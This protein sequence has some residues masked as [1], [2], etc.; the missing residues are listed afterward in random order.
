MVLSCVVMWCVQL[1]NP[2]YQRIRKAKGAEKFMLS[3]GYEISTQT[4]E[5][6]APAAA[7]LAADAAAAQRHAQRTLVLTE[8]KNLLTEC[9]SR[10]AS[11]SAQRRGGSERTCAD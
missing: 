10:L 5:W 9:E 1:Q 8:A 3:A 11:G 2:M 6:S 4:I 7:A